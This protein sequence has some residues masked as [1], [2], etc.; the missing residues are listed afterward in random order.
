MDDLIIKT[1]NINN[2]N[3]AIFDFDWTLVKPKNNRKFPSNTEDWQYLRNSVKETIQ[4]YKLTHHIVIVTNQTKAWKVDQI[5]LVVEDLQLTNDATIIIGFTTHKP[6]TSLFLKAFPNFEENNNDN[7]FFVGDA[8]GRLNDF[9]D[10]DKQFA[11]NLKI[12]FILPEEIFPLDTIEN[13][14]NIDIPQEKEVIIM[15]G[16]PGSGKTTICK[17]IFEK[18]NYHIVSGDILKTTSKM[19]KDAIKYINIKSIVFDSTAGTKEK[20]LEFIQFAQKYNLPVRA[21]WIQTPIDISMERNKQRALVTGSK[22]PDVV[23]YVYRKNFEEPDEEEGFI[24]VK[25]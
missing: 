2:T 1:N 24:L 8:A 23:Y 9:S 11:K 16:Y 15:I 6:D 14:I 22:I 20:R 25:V 18:Y 4:K 10:S 5:K 7:S 3:Y 17:D 19:I 13:N 12:K 21:V